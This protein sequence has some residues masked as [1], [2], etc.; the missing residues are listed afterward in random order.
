[1]L[2][3]GSVRHKARLTLATDQERRHPQVFN[4]FTHEGIGC[5]VAQ[6]V[7]KAMGGVELCIRIVAC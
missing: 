2:G 5:C 1:V 3:E 6:G 4:P 7:G